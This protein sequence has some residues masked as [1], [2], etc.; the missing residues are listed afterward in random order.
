[1]KQLLLSTL[2]FFVCAL[3]G[4]HAQTGTITGTMLDATTTEPLMF[5]NIL[6]EEIGT[7]T[8]TDLDGKFQVDVAPGTY[9]VVASYIGYQEKKISEVIVTEN[10]VTI[11]EFSLSDQIEELVEVVV[12]AKVLERTEN[13]I[14]LLQKR[15]DQIQ[16]GISQQEMN[17]YAVGDAAGAMKK[18]TGAT[19]NN[20]RYV[21][22]RGLGDR[23]SLT[24][25][26]GLIM[27]S[28]DPYRNGA[29]LDLIP[30]NL[31]ENI[32]TSKTFTPDQPGTF[33]GGNVNIKTKAFPERFTLTISA[34]TG[35]NAQSHFVDDFLSYDGG[36]S[37]YFGFD[38]G[39]RD[40]PGLLS[41]PRY[42]RLPRFVNQVDNASGLTNTLQRRGEY[43]D[44]I[45]SSRLDLANAADELTQSFNNQFTPD[46]VSTALDHGFSI[47]F[48][49]QYELFGKPLGVIV[50]GN[51]NKSF[52]NIPDFDRARWKLELDTEGNQ[53]MDNVGDFN[54]TTSTEVA[55]LSGLA[56]I[57]YKFSPSN[58]VSIQG[59]YSHVGTKTGR[60]IF[61]TRP[62]QIVGEDRLWARA[63]LWSERELLSLQASGDHVF[64]KLGNARLEWIV[65]NVESSLDEPDTRYFD[66]N[67]DAGAG[68]FFIDESNG[69]PRPFHF[70]RT[71]DDSQQDYKVDITI[72]FGNNDKNKFKI[73]TLISR[74][75]REF[76][77]QRF[78]YQENSF[79]RVDPATGM[80]RE[81]G[82]QDFVGD[83]DDYLAEDNIGLVGEFPFTDEP[84]DVAYVL[85]NYIV[86]ASDPDNSYTGSENI[87]AVY[88]MVTL[89]LTDRLRFVGG[90]RYE[91][92]DIEVIA[93]DT[94]GTID[95][96]DILPSAS[97]IYSLTEDINI[98]AVFS[99]T[100]ARPNLREIAPFD[101]FDPQIPII[102][103]GNP[104]LE[105]T[106]INNYDV[107]FEWFF[108]PGEVFAVSGYFKTFK[109][110][111]ALYQVNPT[112]NEFQYV[113]VETAEVAGVELEFRKNLDFLGAFFTN[114]K[115]NSN[116]SYIYSRADSYVTDRT[117]TVDTGDR[118]FEG[119]SPFIVNAALIYNDIDRGIESVL[120]LNS[121]GNRLS[122]VGDENAFNIFDAGLSQ[123]D[124]TFIKKFEN[125]INI[126]ATVQNILN[127]RFR[128]FADF[129]G[130]EFDRE[131]F[132]K[133]VTFGFGV[134]YTIR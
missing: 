105:Y 8:T 65:G 6:V 114:F 69:V 110:P 99:Q 18:V 52:L 30:S 78:Q 128:N 87:D 72:P 16:D 112:N 91:R 96:Q 90:A 21:Y 109:N 59:L 47:A 29:Q 37:E 33:T 19:V 53:I 45:Y 89:G 46:T 133:G 20:G 3:L 28:S 67:F 5:A 24:Q 36:D 15:S 77:E 41:Q 31:I 1:M 68:G 93:P 25:L 100:L 108:N 17:R 58:T 10:E 13:T 32:I 55:D 88:G 116:F 22:I 7:G 121:L 43:K 117:T 118:P 14:L 102:F 115:F 39:G 119:Q 75:D 131:D 51:F 97:L 132:R 92:T 23:Y 95:E 98:R 127:A 62:E 123:F 63:L 134:S 74:K 2:A 73:G 122:Q 54:V 70:F 12:T 83:V 113:N 60:F 82:A 40:L 49:N 125:N 104:G 124:F 34:S 80:N 4:L 120:S 81:F 56:G 79:I 85:G 61:G 38:D 71:L 76:V 27:P 101:A 129:N 66:A 9:T 64:E 35:F 86:D 11:L 44:D 26:N 42:S 107:R 130:Q 50:S 94:V 48:G 126:K 103:K 106:N 57:S 111:I 84:G